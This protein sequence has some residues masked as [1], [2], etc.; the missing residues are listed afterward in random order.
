MF[1]Y[2]LS[3]LIIFTLNVTIAKEFSVKKP[4]LDRVE[5]AEAVQDALRVGRRKEFEENGDLMPLPNWQNMLRVQARK[6]EL[7]KLSLRPA[8]RFRNRLYRTRYRLKQPDFG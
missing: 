1:F 6:H 5:N 4:T 8:I 3:F 2:I 7:Y